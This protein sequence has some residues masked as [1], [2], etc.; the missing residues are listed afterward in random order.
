[1]HVIATLGFLKVT[2]RP[3]K[4]TA[5]NE[6]WLKVISFYLQYAHPNPGYSK[7]LQIRN[8]LSD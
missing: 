1:M 3:C 7:A 5:E 4:N 6:S 8:L 2:V